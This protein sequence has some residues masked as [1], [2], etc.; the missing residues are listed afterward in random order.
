MTRQ[1]HSTPE[2]IYEH[3][4]KQMIK[5]CPRNNLEIDVPDLKLP[6]KLYK[7]CSFDKNK[8]NI[9]NFK[10]EKIYFSHVDE[11]N[12]PFEFTFQNYKNF[13]EFIENLP[14]T[15]SKQKYAI[16]LRNNRHRMS[17]EEKN[18]LYSNFASDLKNLN[19]ELIRVCCLSSLNDNILMWSH[20]AQDHTGFCLEFDFKFKNNNLKEIIYPVAYFDEM[21]SILKNPSLCPNNC[22]QCEPVQYKKSWITKNSQWEYEKEWRIL[23]T[24]EELSKTPTEKEDC[25]INFEYKLPEN[26]I[27]K[28]YLGCKI[29]EENEKTITEIAK[30]KKI[31]IY[32][33]VMSPDK[34]ELIDKQIWSP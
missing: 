21:P 9:N 11:F 14:E 32:R 16:R 15:E 18:I 17:Q 30:E 10:G 26:S 6:E 8:H 31:P 34:F 5:I 1:D 27:T 25:F 20:Y 13:D 24:N 22:N 29:N 7:Y 19:M 28:V 23:F 33:K 12:D 4:A 2:E 3:I